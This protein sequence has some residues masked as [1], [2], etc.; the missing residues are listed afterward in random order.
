VAIKERDYDGE[1]EKKWY[2]PGTGIV[3]VKG[4][5]EKLKLVATTLRRR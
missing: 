2:A 4:D 1:K 3:K 5:D